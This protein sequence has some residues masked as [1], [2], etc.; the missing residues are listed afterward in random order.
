[1]T[2]PPL[3]GDAAKTLSKL[4]AAKGGRARASV[5]TQTERSDQARQAVR[6]RWAKAG[7]VATVATTKTEHTAPDVL[8]KEDLPYSMFPGQLVIGAVELK[9]HVLNDGRRVFT[10][11]EVVRALT[12]GTDSSNL[13]RY[14]SRL[15]GFEP[16]SLSSEP[17][18][19]VIPGVSQLATGYEATL[20]VE[21]CDAYLRAR[22]AGQLKSG[23]LKLAQY[24]EVIFRGCA[25]V[26]II[27]LVDE[28]TGY[29]EVRQ[30]H[31]L[32]IKLQAFI[33][34]EM[35]EWAK[36]FPDEFWFELARLEGTHYSAKHRPLRWGK[37]VMA[38]VYDSVDG[39]VGKELRTINPNPAF[40]HNH[41]QW[42]KQHGKD[43]VR[44]QIGKVIGVMRTCADMGEFNRK[45]ANVFKKS[46]LQLDFEDMHWGMLN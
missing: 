8:K 39:D 42:L 17:F 3:S 43:A 25:K 1:M 4:G 32:Q 29:Q 23:Q 41:H 2:T 40:R 20:L 22:D 37:Y 13:N 15:S 28:A 33:A 12:G 11:G 38:F 9:C 46:P 34:E 45:F 18:Q 16:G 36:M 21:I 6:A 35:Q 44:L 26:G 24:A 10:H 30:R 7:K 14:L 31:A 27:A 5:L 19:F